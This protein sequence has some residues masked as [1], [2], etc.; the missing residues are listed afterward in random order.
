MA[1]KHTKIVILAE[2]GIATMPGQ[3]VKKILACAR[4]TGLLVYLVA[5]VIITPYSHSG[6]CRNPLQEELTSMRLRLS[7][8]CCGLGY[9]V[10]R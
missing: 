8:G 5:V 3:G 9:F 2:A 6:E 4:M 10:V 1:I 7:R